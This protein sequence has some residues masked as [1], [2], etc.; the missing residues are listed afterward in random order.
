[1]FADT[2]PKP[3]PGNALQKPDLTPIGQILVQMGK[4]SQ[5]QVDRVLQIQNDSGGRFGEI[6]IRQ[7]FITK[8]D[9]DDVLAIQFG[10]SA[11]PVV[12]SSALPAK[13]T[14]AF[15]PQSPY[16]ESIRSLRSQLVQ[17]WFDG[18]PGQST[19]A[20]TSVDR[21]DGKSFIT[22]SLAV[23]FAQL[24]ER[25]LIID[26]DMRHATQ[27]EVFGLP[28]KFG[29]SGVLSG[30][31]SLD[32]IVTLPGVPNL[33][34]LASGPLPPNP[35]ELLGRPVFAQLLNAL[36]TQFNVILL[37]TPSAQ[38]ASDAHVIA[39]RAGA[40]LIVGRKDRTRSREIAQLAG[41]FSSSGIAI[42]GAT[43]NEY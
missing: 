25:T 18:S 43:F 1:M 6:A 28:N 9:V 31:A 20:I 26:C 2:A 29:L 36:S 11:L 37:D 23:A 4:M 19:L 12:G 3:E 35:Q 41:V 13:I 17:R 7:R 16:A 32:E 42:L 22:S 34:I 30:R 5:Q 10:Y 33:S 40:C 21:G 15:D 27:H 14:R 24:N 8:K 38:E 39:Q